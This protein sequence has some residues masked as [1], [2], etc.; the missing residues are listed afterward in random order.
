MSE[1]LGFITIKETKELEKILCASEGSVVGFSN[2]IFLPV[3]WEY[4]GKTV[5]VS[6]IDSDGDYC[7]LGF[8]WKPEWF[9]PALSKE[10]EQC[11]LEIDEMLAYF[12]GDL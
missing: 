7:A 11:V 1:E 2:V 4:A 6:E 9:R 3:M 10:D 5:P 8:Y 12:L